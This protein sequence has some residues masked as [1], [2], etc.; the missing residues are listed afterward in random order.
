MEQKSILEGIG[1]HDVVTVQNP[2]DE[3]FEG[4]VSRSV[5]VK[6]NRNNPQPTGNATAD[7]FISG[8]QRG[9]DQG[10]HESR[11]HVQQTITF[12]PR[13]ILRLPGDVA[14]VI[15]N[16]MV[17]KYLQEQSRMVKNE[18]GLK[19]NAILIADTVTYMETE[20]LI[21][22]NHESMLSNMN[23]E[24]AEQRLQRQLDDLNPV[25]TAAKE[26]EDEQPFPTENGTV[27]DTSAP[28]R[29]RGRPPQQ[30]A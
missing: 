5:V 7:A 23:I 22:K 16:Q 11:Q 26:V 21:V 30:A 24:T 15:V 14:K 9:I 20:K 8:I 29:K 13:Q 12:S 6:I 17:R 25:E 27:G 3:P 4:K 19:T 2:F 18:K 1:E 10:G 28:A